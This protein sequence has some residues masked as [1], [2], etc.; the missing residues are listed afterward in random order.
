MANPSKDTRNPTTGET[1]QQTADRMA[2]AAGQP[3]PSAPGGPVG[4]PA[5]ANLHPIAQGVYG[6]PVSQPILGKAQ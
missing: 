5:P 3:H 2:G 1:S 6:S 4:K